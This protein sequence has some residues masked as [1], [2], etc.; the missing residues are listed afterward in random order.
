MASDKTILVI[1]DD[2]DI[3]KAVRL[4]LEPLGYKVETV[5]TG[6]DGLQAA[7]RLH[8]NLILLDVMLASPSE[9]FHVAYELK[10]DESSADI[11][12]VILSAVGSAMGLDYAKEVGSAYLPADAF[13]EKPFDAAILRSTIARCLDD[14]HPAGAHS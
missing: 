5:L 14:G 4:I 10:K 13:L 6:T 1:D 7:R 3:H 8:P 12:I 2:K 9:G 11:P